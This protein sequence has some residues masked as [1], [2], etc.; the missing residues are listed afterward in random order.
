M[1]KSLPQVIFEKQKQYYSLQKQLGDLIASCTGMDVKYKGVEG[2]VH[3]VY[4]DGTA[5]VSFMS[6]EDYSEFIENV[7]MSELTNW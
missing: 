4:D 5:D 7:S 6:E 2:V 1:I 3:V